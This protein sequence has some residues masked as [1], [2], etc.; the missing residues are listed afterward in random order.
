MRCLILILATLLAAR[1]LADPAGEQ[2]FEAK[3]RPLL[4]ERCYFCHS[5]QAKKLKGG[6]HLDSREGA[7][8]G[9]E[10]GAAL[11]PGAPDK[12]RLIEAVHYKNVDLQMPP[13]DKLSDQQIADLTAWVK[14]GAPWGKA[15]SATTTAAPIA[16]LDAFDLQKR[17]AAHWAWQPV[18]AQT[19]PAVKD[20]AWPRGPIDRF[21]LAKLEE[22]S[23]SPAAP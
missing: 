22:Q 12:S 13:K 10:T 1:P 23:I 3:I 6:L 15:S 21:I 8:K 5:S 17:K 18:Q 19:P 20:A 11:E 2:F 4:V 9:G 7:L 14:M 16:K